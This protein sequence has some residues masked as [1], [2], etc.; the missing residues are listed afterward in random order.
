MSA[1][2][3]VT[4]V[5]YSY[6][7]I[8]NKP[9]TPADR[10][11]LADIFGTCVAYPYINGKRDGTLTKDQQ[12][13]DKR[14]LKES[15]VQKFRKVPETVQ[16]PVTWSDATLQ[17][18]QPFFQDAP[19]EKDVPEKYRI[20]TLYTTAENKATAGMSVCGYQSSWTNL[21]VWPVQLRH[22]QTG[23]IKYI[24]LGDRNEEL[25]KLLYERGIKPI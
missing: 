25:R 6:M 14:T 18:W 24:Y 10:Q 7:V 20:Q 12:Q 21:C 9:G 19:K 4:S 15:N 1:Y 3:K 23:H 22:I 8:D 2:N 5:P 17:E 13:P 16:M 11:V